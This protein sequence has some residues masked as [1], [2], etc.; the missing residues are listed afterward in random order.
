M[1][2]PTTVAMR[3]APHLQR[4]SPGTFV[5][6]PRGA[7][8]PEAGESRALAGGKKDRVLVISMKRTCLL[9]GVP[10]GELSPFRSS[11]WRRPAK[12]FLAE[13]E[14]EYRARD[15]LDVQCE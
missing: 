13:D 1:R 6:S 3:R 8:T 4:A 5:S 10:F 12:A 15:D 2:P 9:A 7:D 11:R 14:H